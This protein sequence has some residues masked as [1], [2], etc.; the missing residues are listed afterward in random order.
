[1]HEH[2]PPLLND[3]DSGGE[4]GNQVARRDIQA[5]HL[6][7]KFGDSFTTVRPEHERGGNWPITECGQSLYGLPYL[8]FCLCCDVLW[9]HTLF[10]YSM[11]SITKGFYTG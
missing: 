10:C 5:C 2:N 3:S 8:L 7:E 6:P 9:F 4:D 11:S 1:M